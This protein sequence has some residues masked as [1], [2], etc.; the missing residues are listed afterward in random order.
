[1][2]QNLK[3]RH[4][5][6]LILLPPVAGLLVFCMREVVTDYRLYEELRGTQALARL[7]VQIGALC[8]ELQKERGYSSGYLNAR[9]EKFGSELQAQRARV[10]A[11]SEQVRIYL[12]EHPAAAA[13]VKEPLAAAESALTRLKET[14]AGISAL[15]VAGPDSYAFYTGIISSYLDV[16]AA[17]ATSSGKGEVMRDATAFYAFIKAKEET[18]KERATLNAVLS[19]GKFDSERFQRSFSNL[20]GQRTY[21][22]IFRKYGSPEVLALYKEKEASPAF[23]KVEEVRNAVLAKGTAGGFG[24]T[25]EEWFSTSTAKIDSMKEVEDFQS[26]HILQ[27]AEHMA[28]KARGALLVGL[29]LAVVLTCV[30]LGSG[31]AVMMS[32]TTPLRRLLHVLHDIAEG[33]GDLTR[34]LDVGRRDE[35]GEVSLWFNRFV[36]SVH[37]IATQVSGTAA[38]VS[39]S[40]HEMNATAEHISASVE[41]VA[42]QSSTLATAGEEMS[43]TST[44]IS[45]NCLSAAAASSRAGETAQGGAIVVQET[46]TG[47]EKIAATVQDSA[48]TIASLGERSDQ[49]G[50]IVETIEEIADQTNLLALN[51]AIEAARAGEQGRGFAVVADEVRA[52][53]ERTTRATKEIGAMIKAIQGETAGAVASMETGIGEVALGMESSRKSGAALQDILAVIGEVNMQVHEIATAAEEQSAVSAEMSMGIHRINEVVCETSEGASRTAHA[54]A[55]LEALAADLQRMVGRFRLA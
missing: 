55:E 13:A 6:M 34:R 45:R 25:A 4:K 11:V 44:D 3:I 49:I 10:D 53:A 7:E 24:T 42:V 41:H 22:D 35:L 36:D 39:A 12:S 9:G 47:M 38:R 31:F 54:A 19:E 33:E 52:L 30:A 43:A 48:R 26:R 14:R 32:I 8:H 37:G 29:C 51:A 23:A 50:E 1:M 28:A 5:L 27:L 18:G 16:A 17:V 15:A 21:L 40:V 20:A 2:L 46:L